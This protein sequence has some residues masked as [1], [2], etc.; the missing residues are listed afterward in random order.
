M[1]KNYFEVNLCNDELKEFRVICNYT[2]LIGIREKVTGK[3]INVKCPHEAC[4]TNY[5]LTCEK[6]C[7]I[8]SEEDAKD[9]LKLFND[10]NNKKA[11][12]EYLKKVEEASFARFDNAYNDFKRS[13]K[14]HSKRLIRSLIK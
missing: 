13:Q 11:Y 3:T 9:Y 8:V 14:E 12:K 2:P 10:E 6:E 1:K 5:G 4:I 7:K